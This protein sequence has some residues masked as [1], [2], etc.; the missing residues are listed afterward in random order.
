MQ[1]DGARKYAA[2]DQ[3]SAGM[4]IER[5][6]IR[7]LQLPCHSTH[8]V[9]T[10]SKRPAQGSCLLGIKR[11][12]MV[13]TI[14][15]NLVGW[16]NFQIFMLPRHGRGAGRSDSRPPSPCDDAALNSHISSFYSISYRLKSVLCC[17]LLFMN[18]N[19]AILSSSK[20]L[21]DQV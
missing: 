13:L 6:E 5:S 1:A 16:H 17:R 9:L 8:Y 15:S 3:D 7:E 14:K 21:F 2:G 10:L 20:A 18:N 19:N 11:A 4:K 12:G